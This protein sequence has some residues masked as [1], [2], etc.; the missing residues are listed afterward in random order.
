MEDPNSY[1]V[2]AGYHGS[3]LPPFDAEN[4]DVA[5]PFVWW[6]GYCH[7]ANVLFP[8]WHRAYVQ[9]LEDALRTQ[10]TPW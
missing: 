8:L 9:H 2:I 7:H 10:V 4:P 5:P 6:G 3:P 1:W